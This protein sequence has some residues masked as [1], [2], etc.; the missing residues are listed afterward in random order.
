MSGFFK[1]FLEFFEKHYFSSSLR[2]QMSTP[3][4]DILLLYYGK[5]CIRNYSCVIGMPDIP[6]VYSAGNV[7]HIYSFLSSGMCGGYRN[8]QYDY[9]AQGRQNIYRT[10]IAYSQ[11]L[12]NCKTGRQ[13]ISIYAGWEIRGY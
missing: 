2:S 10:T 5:I 12:V 8:M 7:E 13:V 3:E 4:M 1:N 6:M 9:S 11:E